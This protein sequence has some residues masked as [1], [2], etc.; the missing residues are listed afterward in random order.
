[1]ADI[2]TEYVTNV[3]H[4]VVVESHQNGGLLKM[5]LLLVKLTFLSSDV[6]LERRV[7]KIKLKLSSLLNIIII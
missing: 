3:N 4:F 7:H 2:Y 1:M 6:N 5:L